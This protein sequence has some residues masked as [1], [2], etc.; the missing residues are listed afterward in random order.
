MDMGVETRGR[1]GLWWK[2]FESG[3]WFFQRP[4]TFPFPFRLLPS[5]VALF[6]ITSGRWESVQ[7]DIVDR[8]FILRFLCWCFC[9]LFLSLSPPRCR[10]S[11]RMGGKAIMRWGWAANSCIVV[12]THVN[13]PWSW[14]FCEMGTAVSWGGTPAASTNVSNYNHVYCLKFRIWLLDMLW[15][16]LSWW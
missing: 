12:G 5:A 6:D 7:G 16:G 9:F 10:V 15:V 8:I 3:P 4:H 13:V 1:E 11:F 2:L 14:W